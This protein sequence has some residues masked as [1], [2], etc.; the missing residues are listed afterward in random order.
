MTSENSDKTFSQKARVE[1]IT[2]G[3]VWYLPEENRWRDM[4]ML[5]MRDVGLLV[6]NS[7]SLEFHG[8]KET[9]HITGITG[10]TCGKQGRDFVNDWIKVEYQEGNTA[11]FADGS[12]LGWG[13]V[14]G[15]TRRILE[16]VRHLGQ[17][18]DAL[19][20][21][22][23]H[24]NTDEKLKADVPPNQSLHGAPNSTVVNAEVMDKT[25]IDPA[26]EQF[27][28]KTRATVRGTTDANT[29]ADRPPSLIRRP[30]F[31]L[32]GLGGTAML[33]CFLCCGGL[34]LL[35]HMASEDARRMREQMAEARRIEEAADREQYA[36]AGRLW[37]SGKKAE[38]AELY[39]SL[40]DRT[41]FTRDQ[42][43]KVVRRVIEFDLEQGNDSIAKELMDEAFGRNLE[44][45]PIDH[46]RASRL[47]AQVQA[48]R[49]QREAERRA[50]E[51]EERKKQERL[52]AARKFD[53]AGFG[54]ERDLDDFEEKYPGAST[55]SDASEERERLTTRTTATT[56][57]Q[58]ECKFHRGKLWQV[59]LRYDGAGSNAALMEKLTDM[60]GEPSGGP[61]QSS[62]GDEQFWW[63]F[64]EA[65][66]YIGV[67]L[68]G[69]NSAKVLATNLELKDRVE[70]ALSEASER[71]QEIAAAEQRQAERMRRQ[72]AESESRNTYDSGSHQSAEDNASE[73]GTDPIIQMYYNQGV[74]VARDRI[75]KL[76]TAGND[77]MR[78]Q[79]L[80]M[81]NNELRNARL[82]A[83]EWSQKPNHEDLNGWKVA[84]GYLGG[85]E[86]TYATEGYSGV[87]NGD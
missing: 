71:R 61:K 69:N 62:A 67:V 41:H 87:I 45:L 11:F 57:C 76:K 40:V 49:E 64:S 7:D 80:K 79:L 25:G 1:K 66:R 18:H 53:I 29:L 51:E 17:T 78:Q 73:P 8:T 42:Q 4:K 83:L 38:A 85:L 60:F 63:D 12:W 2:F 44:I 30:M 36:E 72:V 59:E 32:L 21:S 55:I 27:R 86:A 34:G 24:R 70:V 9:I 13:G 46:P 22:R 35:I 54:F 16:A 37:A 81:W 3:S 75:M 23:V 77:A 56:E 14:L 15:G 19:N 52:E 39:R 43:T 50:R 20:G 47:V 48:E 5:A 6:I 68:R 31:W 58:M 26:R 33:M 65:G 10:I 84:A 82:D 74:K 28:D